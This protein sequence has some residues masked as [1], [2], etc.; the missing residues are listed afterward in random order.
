VIDGSGYTDYVLHPASR[1]H[2]SHVVAP[3]VHPLAFEYVIRLDAKRRMIDEAI[4]GG[5]AMPRRAAG[6]QAVD[7]ALWRKTF[8]KDIEKLGGAAHSLL[9]LDEAVRERQGILDVA[10][11][12]GTI[13]DEN[14]TLMLEMAEEDIARYASAIRDSMDNIREVID[15]RIEMWDAVGSSS[16]IWVMEIVGRAG[17]AEATLFAGDLADLYVKYFADC[18]PEW[19]VEKMFLGD[20]EYED[21][22]VAATT[23]N[24][25]AQR[26]IIR[27]EGVFSFLRHEI[28]VHK[29]QRVPVTEASGRMQTSTATVTIMPVLTPSSVDLQESDCTL[30]FVRGSGPGGQGMQSSSNACVLTHRPSGITVK[31]HQSRSALGNKELAMQKVAQ[32]LLAAKAREQ[33]SVNSNVWA[34]QYASGERSERMRTYNWPQNRVTD[35][36]LNVDFPL[37]SFMAAG[38]ML[39][40]VHQRLSDVSRRE[41]C[42]KAL[43]RYVKGGF[44]CT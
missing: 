17:G 25:G 23:E 1:A 21:A 20:R 31:C 13:L 39:F 24:P 30:D 36:R 43:L 42:E 7:I 15:N 2:L 35:H 38:A 11:S 40:K 22:V 14:S 28:G 27:G 16:R 34:M 5:A 37:T 10:K 12:R 26:F 9:K 33:A 4:Q 41:A 29:V 44:D 18:Q 32:Q 8:D 3:D 19:R 6:G